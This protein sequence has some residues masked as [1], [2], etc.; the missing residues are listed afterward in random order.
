MHRQSG[1][2]S[3]KLDVYKGG[4]DRGDVKDCCQ[5]KRGK[6]VRGITFCVCFAPHKPMLFVVFFQM[7]DFF[8]RRTFATLSTIAHLFACV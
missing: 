4:F 7:C 3:A 2:H 5:P 8:K 1:E 6:V